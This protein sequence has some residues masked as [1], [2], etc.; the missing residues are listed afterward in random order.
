MPAWLESGSNG[1]NWTY[2]ME[3]RQLRRNRASGLDVGSTPPEAC[4]LYSCAGSVG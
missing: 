4:K 3:T 1:M 2:T